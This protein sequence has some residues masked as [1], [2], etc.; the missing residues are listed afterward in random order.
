MKPAV[1]PPPPVISGSSSLL[2]SKE[3]CDVL[4]HNYMFREKGTN[5]VHL[6][7]NCKFS[8]QAHFCVLVTQDKICSHFVFNQGKIS[9]NEQNSLTFLE[10]FY[11]CF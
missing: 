5:L 9:K 4:G 8:L 3:V 1:P 2:Y 11:L 7:I 6:L 10:H